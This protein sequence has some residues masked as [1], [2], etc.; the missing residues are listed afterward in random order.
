[1]P[2]HAFSPSRHPAI[3]HRWL[4]GLLSALAS[5]VLLGSLAAPA[6]AQTVIYVNAAAAPGG[7]GQSWGTA[8]Q[9]LQAAITDANARILAL[10]AGA[11]SGGNIDLWIAAG[12]YKTEPVLGGFSLAGASS[13]QGPGFLRAFGG[14]AGNESHVEQRDPTVRHT[15]LTADVLG[16]DGPGFTNRSD[17][18]G[19]VLFVGTYGRA[20][21]VVVRGANG[22]GVVVTQAGVLNGCVIIDNDSPG[23]GGGA[24]VHDGQ[25]IGCKFIGNRAVRGGGVALFGNSAAVV[26]CLF[27][28][29]HA[30]AVDDCPTC[31]EGG[32]I[33]ITFGGSVRNCTF[34][35]NTAARLSVVALGNTS[36]E[37]CALVNS[38][39]FG[40]SQ[41]TGPSI[42]FVENAS[43]GITASHNVLDADPG[44]G[45]PAL[46]VGNPGLLAPAG[47]D[48][49][50]GTIDDSPALAPGSPCIDTGSADLP[51]YSPDALNRVRTADGDNDGL[52]TVDR[53]ASEFGAPPFLPVVFVRALA[54][55]GGDGTT[56]SRAFQAV[57][58]A[59]TAF[60]SEPG[61]QAEEVWIAEG[62][63][64]P[65]P[66]GAPRE[67]ASLLLF[68]PIVIRG[69]FVGTESTAA[70]AN[71]DLH[72]TVL[73]ADLNGD[74]SIG[75]YMD[76]APRII[77]VFAPGTLIDGFSFVGARAIEFGSPPSGALV[78]NSCG[79]L[80]VSRCVFRENVGDFGSALF[81]CGTGLVVSDCLFEDN[82]GVYGEPDFQTVR[83]GAVY[84]FSGAVS[85]VLERCVFRR[86]RALAGAAIAVFGAG[87][88]GQPFI[89]RN[90]LIEDHVDPTC[91]AVVS[92]QES[93]PVALHNTSV[94]GNSIAG[95]AVSEVTEVI[96]CLIAQN[97]SSAPGPAG[98]GSPRRT[99]ILNT[100]IASNTAAG[101]IGAG[102]ALDSGAA[103]SLIANSIIYG[104][105]NFT[106]GSQAEQVDIA[107]PAVVGIVEFS[108]NLIEAWNGLILSLGTGTTDQNPRF[109]DPAN[110][111][112]R[113]GV[114]SPAIDSANADPL[115]D[116]TTG[117]FRILTDL[118][119]LPRLVDQPSVPN[120][121][122]GAL[123]HLDRGC[124]EAQV[125]CPECPGTRDWINPAGGQFAA[126]INWFPSVPTSLHDARFA[127]PGAYTVS[128]PAAA[129]VSTR[130]VAFRDGEVSL[131]VPSSTTYALSSTTTLGLDISGLDPL[132][133]SLHLS[134]G[135]S[136]RSPDIAIGLAPQTRGTLRVS[137]PGT[138]LRAT[139]NLI[140][141][142]E[143]A[144]TLEVLGGARVVSRSA[145]IGDQP[146]STGLARVSGPGSR[147]DIPF[148]LVVDKGE[149]IVEDGG[150]LS[151]SF[152]TYLFN[153]GRVSGNGTIVG[154]VINFG[155]LEPGQTGSSV[156]G[157]LFI[158]GSYEQ[159][160]EIV[161]LGGAS[162]L[163]SLDVSGTSAGQFDKLVIAGETKL[164]GGLIV[165]A[166]LGGFPAP[167]PEGL[168][169]PLIDALGG[170]GI[171]DTTG[172]PADHVDVAF[173]PRVPGP[174]GGPSDQFLRL[175]RPE[176]GG[177]QFFNLTT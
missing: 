87:S 48:G 34:V 143:G 80:R 130:S 20:D 23:P 17:N 152:G 63:Y 1:M 22:S 33:D 166:P 85:G 81:A 126:P 95:P 134:G 57:Q 73:S 14:F 62:T 45:D 146:G 113:L 167:P 172:M 140:I 120:T 119:G 112:F 9:D 110:G 67:A 21:G 142:G 174:G 75:A 31:G 64:L 168:S 74:D 42:G 155:R 3:S 61:R 66:P 164:G 6:S 52:R 27:S 124:Y 165:Q 36:A 131:V 4:R 141:G 44:F 156:I 5:V 15:I 92:A 82:G 114:G 32:A 28:A 54:A 50:L 177:A 109:I 56:W 72:R 16:D 169:L 49:L 116:G 26:N 97:I 68:S 47:L 71:P 137:G 99:T 18:Q 46:I 115:V 40:N 84:V 70:Q 147:W 103:N 53:G 149:A 100:T 111:D 132:S 69:G 60:G 94:I 83:G 38:V 78:G 65:G 10:T 8:Y 138:T 163:L 106:G 25:V 153:E 176:G 7:D 118:V 135:G 19:T 102:I 35:G 98:F 157:Q 59:V 30:P 133:S 39:A 91:T 158:N 41:A 96:G 148:F 154:D 76:N 11:Q 24:H 117:Q 105:R 144:G 104:N 55:P 101:G 129:S 123:D 125:S 43:G 89:I 2:A 12:T 139:R 86:N 13:N 88:A 79:L 170:I 51:L 151:T 107:V 162:G 160:G 77:D 37:T 161:D 150:T 108:S 136:L 159:V 175:E 128:L 121:G 145:A 29:N 90:C 127:L 171:S 58:D 173:Y 93:A 122:T